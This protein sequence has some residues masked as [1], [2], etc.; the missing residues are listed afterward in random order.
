MDIATS[1]EAKS[2]RCRWPIAQSWIEPPG[3]ELWV[4]AL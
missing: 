3:Y 1:L 4:T 2:R